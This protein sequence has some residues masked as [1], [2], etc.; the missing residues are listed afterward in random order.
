M[1]EQQIQK[2]MCRS[3]F[4]SGENMTKTRFTEK[5]IELINTLEK[6]KGVTYSISKEIET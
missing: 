4:K 3:V 6:S 1:V 5:W 2:P